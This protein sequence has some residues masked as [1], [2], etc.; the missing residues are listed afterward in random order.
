MLL[1]PKKLVL[2]IDDEA[3]DVWVERMTRRQY[4]G[5]VDIQ[6]RMVS[7]QQESAELVLE[8]V[9][10]DD[11][12]I[13]EENKDYEDHIKARDELQKKIDRINGYT[14]KEGI[15]IP[16]EIEELAV[17]FRDY[18]FAKVVSFDGKELKEYIYKDGKVDDDLIDEHF[19]NEIYHALYNE[20]FGFFSARKI[21]NEPS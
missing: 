14:D 13:T 21:G 17:E 10:M 15:E 6:R 19:D 3:H 4:E 5:L 1:K 18:M 12:G 11:L 2:K 16:G 8:V 7:K 20:L 9:A